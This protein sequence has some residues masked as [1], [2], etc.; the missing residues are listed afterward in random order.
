ML[1]TL[2]IKNIALITDVTVELLDGLN[3]LS[4]ET[5]AGKSIVIDSLNFVLG[6]RADKGLIR[7]GED[8]AQVEAVFENY[9]T[10]NV[11]AFLDSQGIE[12]EEVLILR[13]QMTVSGKNE[14]RINGNLVTLSVLKGLTELL[15]DIHGQ[16]EHQSLLK[17]DNHLLLL[18]AYGGDKIAS[19]KSKVAKIYSEL[20]AYEK[21]LSAFGADD[22]RERR[23]DIL[24]YQIE[25]IEKANLSDPEEEDN[26]LAERK[27][28]RNAEKI[29][30]G[31]EESRQILDGYEQR[32]VIAD[33]NTA[34][35]LLTQI[36][37]YDDE[38]KEIVGRIESAKIELRDVSDTLE[39]LLDSNAFDERRLEW[40]ENRLSVIRQVKKKYGATI[41]DVTEFYDKIKAEHDMLANSA[42]LVEE[43]KENIEK[44]SS[45]LEAE[46]EKLSELRKSF[47]K[48]FEK[49]IF[50]ELKDLGMGNSTFKVDFKPTAPASSGSDKV[51]FLISPNVGEP[52]KELA[53]IISGGEM[54][55]FMLALKNITARLDDIG[56]MV[57]D[58]ID[59]G[60]SGN[61]AQVVA[62][63]LYNIAYD[64]QVIAVTHLPQLAS[65]ADTHY[66]IEKT[67]SGG[68]T[69][70]NLKLLSGDDEIREL[71]RLAGGKEYSDYAALHA[72]EM[73][74]HALAYK[75]N[76]KKQA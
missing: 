35:Q 13:R 66:L 4:G 26:L 67:V 12:A 11:G 31:L 41:S 18:D 48:K 1:K 27:K 47:A 72:T 9:L 68:K 65:M 37:D 63:K 54:S 60:I 62:E 74:K 46:C 53:K 10:P 22:D 43:L 49:D 28:F 16:H 59:T 5:G 20:K 30:S 15:C 33:L 55:R 7:F 50:G 34:K 57:F 23:L 32:S 70:T 75:E 64:R 58:E 56:T 73:K 42:E 2:H 21:Q 36:S 40:I 51:E 25:E 38:I 69:S 8:K 52:L 19:Q 14:C 6:E 3:I 44:T 29:T 61:I 71:A 17:T 39:Q 45:K 24:S 76:R